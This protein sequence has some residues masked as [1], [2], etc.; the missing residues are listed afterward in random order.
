MK[1]HIIYQ[2]PISEE[3]ISFEKYEKLRVQRRKRVS[4]RMIKRFPLFAKEFM[5]AE[6]PEVTEEMIWEES[7]PGRKRKSF[8]KKKTPLQHQG[9]YPLM[10]KALVQYS[11]TKDPAHLYEAQRLRNNI[12]KSFQLLYQLGGEKREYTLP[13]TASISVVKQLADISFQSW[14]DLDRQWDEVT[15]WGI[16]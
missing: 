10:K 16:S 11:L 13:S 5:S 8:R 6:F 2:A 7:K 1:S 4:K 9:R 14:D 15:K 3:A 12:Y